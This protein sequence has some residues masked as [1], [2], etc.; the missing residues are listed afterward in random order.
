MYKVSS[1][2]LLIRRN[3]IWSFTKA[4]LFNQLYSASSKLSKNQ[5]RGAVETTLK[6]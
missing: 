1:L 2:V 6:K 3:S 4:E 5:A